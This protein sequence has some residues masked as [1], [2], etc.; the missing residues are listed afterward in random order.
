MERIRSRRLLTSLTASLP[1][2][3]IPIGLDFRNRDFSGDDESIN[4]GHSGIGAVTGQD[5]SLSPSQERVVQLYL[6]GDTSDDVVIRSFLVITTTDGNDRLDDPAFTDP[7]TTIADI[8]EFGGWNGAA[9]G[10]LASIPFPSG[11]DFVIL[12]TGATGGYTF[13]P[14]AGAAPPGTG[15]LGITGA[16][17]QIGFAQYQ[18]DIADSGIS[19]AA[20]NLYRLRANIYSPNPNANDDV[21]LFFGDEFQTGLSIV[22]YNSDE[23]VPSGAATLSNDPSNVW[24]AY[25]LAEGSGPIRIGADI[26]N[27]GTGSGQA[28]TL[29]SIQ[30]RELPSPLVN[31]G[32]GTTIFNYG[33]PVATPIA[34]EGSDIV[35]SPDGF[36]AG[37]TVGVGWE[38]GALNTNQPVTFN[39]SANQLGITYGAVAGNAP[40]SFGQLALAG[41]S[42]V[43]PTVP[44]AFEVANDKLYMLDVWASTST[45]KTAEKTFPTLRVGVG[46][47]ANYFAY[48]TYIMSPVAGTGTGATPL[49]TAIQTA[50]RA[51]TLVWH[52]QVSDS[53]AQATLAIVLL[54][55]DNVYPTASTINI[56]RVTLRE[57]A[58]PPN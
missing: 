21:R 5:I 29:N 3:V 43:D 4:S 31:L 30:V 23:Q 16:A 48:N 55:T 27:L 26:V 36:T 46:Q 41:G 20:N 18:L 17:S 38:W 44:G 53:V 24:D 57:F 37:S 14:G 15:S 49:Q 13:S 50:P 10:I 33:G 32:T 58:L 47:Q 19:V 40:P 1:L 11:N 9:L 39:P 42:A 28:Y 8:Q 35:A 56:H 7:W 51:Y 45:P 54:S 2:I 22:A 12:G 25:L 52:P 6:K 34:E